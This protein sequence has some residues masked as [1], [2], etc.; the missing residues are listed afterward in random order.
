MQCLEIPHLKLEMVANSGQCFRMKALDADAYRVLAGKKQVDITPLGDNRFQLSCEESETDGWRRYFD[1]ETDY[2]PL[3]TEHR[4]ELMRLYCEEDLTL[5]EIADQM[6][7]TRQGVSDALN[8]ARRQLD[9]YEQ[10]LGLVARYRALTGQAQRCLE[11]L[12]RSVPAA[13]II[14]YVTEKQEF[15]IYLE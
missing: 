13:Q 5:A 8:K 7:I 6:D 3:L 4:R 12:K 2:G 1:M 14:G 9:D 11:E 15:A 10:K